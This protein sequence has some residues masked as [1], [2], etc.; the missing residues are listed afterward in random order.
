MKKLSIIISPSMIR[1]L[2]MMIIKEYNNKEVL[3]NLKITKWLK[4]TLSPIFRNSNQWDIS[5]QDIIV[6]IVN[7]L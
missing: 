5:F 7:S 3:S 2:T 4:K 1:I 6:Q